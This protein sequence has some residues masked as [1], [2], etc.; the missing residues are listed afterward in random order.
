M[1]NFP[2]ID[3]HVHLW[4]PTHFRMAWTDGAPTL[5]KP[6]GVKDYAEHTSGIRIEAMVYLEVDVAPHYS[7][8]EVAWVAECAK[9]DPRLKA[10][11]AHAPL[12][13]GEQVRAYLAAL[14]Q[15]SPLVRGI[16]RLVQQEP[17][18][19]FQLLPRF[20]RGAQLLAEFGLSCDL[21]IKHPQL[22]ATIELVARC[23]DT[24]F[25][26]DHIGKP[27]IASGALQPW[28][29]G[30][31]EL[32]RLPNVI[33]KVSGMVTEADF[34]RWTVDDLRPYFDTVYEAFGEDRVAFGGDWPVCTLAS[35]YVRW[36]KALDMLS[37]SLSDSAKRKLWAENAR[38]FY[39]L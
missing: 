4:D 37:A 23:P 22:P 7:L 38:A 36:V 26:L 6:Y 31:F 13:Y 30:I 9:Q 28:R 10:I 21:C 33:C 34:G 11:V 20:V 17:D 1:P 3:S 18:D 29:N 25:I 32:A 5:N 12:E 27:N 15:A 16:R 2:I 14:K 8:M 39:R 19:H 35:S 24:R